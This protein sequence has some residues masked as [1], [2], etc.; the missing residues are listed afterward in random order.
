LLFSPRYELCL[1]GDGPHFQDGPGAALQAAF[2]LGFE[3]AGYYRRPLEVSSAGVG[4]RL[5]TIS[6]RGLAVLDAWR[7]ARSGLRLGLG[8]GAD[9]V[10]VS[11]FANPGTDVRLAPSR[12]RKLALARLQG[13][14]ARRVASFMDL[15]LGLGADLDLSDTRYVVQRADGASSVFAPWRL[16]PFVAVGARVP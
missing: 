3:L 11:A 1:M 5:Q 15:E 16:R 4:A 6:F 9:W 8:L 10:R 12:W 14:Y 7:G 2:P 13:N